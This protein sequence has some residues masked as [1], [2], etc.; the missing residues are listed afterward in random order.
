MNKDRNL[1]PL[2][3]GRSRRQ[4]LTEMPIALGTLLIGATA[5]ADQQQPAAN[6]A[7]SSA[8]NRMRTSL[9]YQ[10]DLKAAPQRVYEAL[11][12]AKQFAAFTGL[13]TEIDPKSGGAFSLFAG[14][15]VGR[16]V[17]LIPYQRIVQAWRPAHWAAGVYSIVKFEM[18][19][20]DGESTL[21]LDHT[22]FPEGDADG[23]DSGWHMHYLSP[24]QKYFS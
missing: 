18:K 24:L 11:L 15:I 9:H 4:L 7:A 17:E 13:A 2:A 19:P 23:L 10:V 22:G 16:N 8:A 5:C 3:S 20:R 14:Q 21:V 6:N 12:N 1:F